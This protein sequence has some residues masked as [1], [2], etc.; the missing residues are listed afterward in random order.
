MLVRDWSGHSWFELDRGNARG[1]LHLCCDQAVERVD[2]WHRVK[3]AQCSDVV[4]DGTELRMRKILP[5]QEAVCGVV[6]S[7]L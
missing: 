5:D 3:G 4:V 2:R 1:D 6:L 7:K